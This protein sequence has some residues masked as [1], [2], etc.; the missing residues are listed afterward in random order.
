MVGKVEDPPRRVRIR[1]YQCLNMMR[2]STTT[3]VLDSAEPAC[4]AKLE[5][6]RAKWGIRRQGLP[7]H[8]GYFMIETDT[9][10]VADG[11]DIYLCSWPT[12]EKVI[13]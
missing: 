9:V 1:A 2:P 8:F 5:E 10:M 11:G 4:E 13:R 7:D 6:I 12:E 3:V